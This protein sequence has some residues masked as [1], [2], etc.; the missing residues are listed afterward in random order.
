MGDCSGVLDG[1]VT[2]DPLNFVTYNVLW[3]L[4]PFSKIFFSFFYQTRRL[5]WFVLLLP[6]SQLAPFIFIMSAPYPF[7]VT[8][9]VAHERDPGRRFSY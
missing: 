6:L 1:E 7:N 4:T 2:S 9:N 3:T 8:L 5:A